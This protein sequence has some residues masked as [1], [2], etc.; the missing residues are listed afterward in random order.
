MKINEFNQPKKINEGW[1]DT[2]LGPNLGA[3]YAKPEARH[4]A[5]LKV[6]LDDFVGDAMT[7]LDNGI[8]SG[9][10]DPNITSSSASGKSDEDPDASSNP[11]PTPG[12]KTP[13]P[14][15]T[16][17]TVAAAKG[18]RSGVTTAQAAK[19][20]QRT[21]N[22]ELRTA[23]AAAQKKPAFQQTADDKIAIQKARQAG[24]ISESFDRLNFIFESIIK[25][26]DSDGEVM[27]ISQ[28]MEDW[29]DLYMNG[30]NWRAK[31]NIVMPKIRDVEKT[32][33]TDGGKAAIENLGR[34]AFAIS[35]PAGQAP[36]GAKDINPAPTAPA[37]PPG[38]KS[39]EQIKSDLASLS[40]RDREEVIKDVKA[41]T[42]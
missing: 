26:L 5:A 25:E 9:I 15:G 4:Q 16:E 30:V 11:A 33:D 3:K 22:D 29:F 39:K 8:K 10:I 7:S 32:Y 21:A 17:K 27:S 18:F 36:S 13:G 19:A 35:G 28:Y 23:A 12:P 37:S 14:S 24:L 41:A 34:L 1:L 42:K 2:L 6:F 40:P 38:K 20:D 31:Q